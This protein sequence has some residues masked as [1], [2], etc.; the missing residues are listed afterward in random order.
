MVFCPEHPKLDQ[1]LKFT[2]LSETTS[3]PAPFTWEPPRI[4]RQDTFLSSPKRN[5]KQC[6]CNFWE[7]GR[8]GQTSCILEEV[9]VADGPWRKTC[10]IFIRKWEYLPI[11]EHCSITIFLIEWEFSRWDMILHINILQQQQISWQLQEAFRTHQDTFI[12]DA[13]CSSATFCWGCKLVL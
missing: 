12:S 11:K 6:L 8:W 4:P 5:W 13:C 1:N 7:G 3:I 2:P 10:A 9:E